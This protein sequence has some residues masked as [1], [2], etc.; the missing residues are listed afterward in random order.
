MVSQTEWLLCDLSQ[1]SSTPV[2]T[3]KR[4]PRGC[5]LSSTKLGVTNWTGWAGDSQGRNVCL[6]MMCLGAPEGAT[7]NFS[8]SGFKAEVC[9]MG[10]KQT[11]FSHEQLEEYQ[12]G[13]R[14]GSCQA[15]QLGLGYRQP[16]V[17]SEPRL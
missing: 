4:L 16:R 14:G 17:S 12:V 5:N 6:D 8:S 2:D 9:S 7:C 3:F 13:V 10:N 15:A 1:T 11:V